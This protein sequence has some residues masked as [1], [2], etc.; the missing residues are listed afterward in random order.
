MI[1]L[2]YMYKENCINGVNY[3]YNESIYEFKEAVTHEVID[4]FYGKWKNGKFKR[5]IKIYFDEL[6]KYFDICINSKWFTN[7]GYTNI[8]DYQRRNIPRNMS[9][10]KRKQYL[11]D[12]NNTLELIRKDIIRY[13][14]INFGTILTNYG[15]SIVSREQERA[16]LERAQREWNEKSLAEKIIINN[17]NVVKPQT[18][19][20]GWIIYIICLIFEIIL[21][22]TPGLWFMTT[23]IFLAWRRN[24]INKY[25]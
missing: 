19:T 24:E 18:L 20:E 4:K 1:N 5:D 15:V 23:V 11:N 8:V 9:P 6:D 21:V 25:N 7:R 3:R 2:D 16:A 22:N 14:R 10:E 12:L 13:L 17:T